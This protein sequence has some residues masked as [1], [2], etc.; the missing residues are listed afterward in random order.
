MLL[1]SLT[2]RT[3]NTPF[4]MKVQVITL[5]SKELI[6]RLRKAVKDAGFDPWFIEKRQWGV[7]VRLRRVTVKDAE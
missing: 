1:L 4:G 7:R 6:H 3:M 5:R 2:G